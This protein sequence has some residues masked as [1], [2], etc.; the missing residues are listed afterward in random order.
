[1][2]RALRFLLFFSVMVGVLV[3][4]ILPALI[5][6]ML[7]QYVR[8]L[9][10]RADTLTVSV[11]TFDPALLS[12]RAGR[13]RVEGTNV[14]IGRATVGRLDITLGNVSFFDRSFGSVNGQ[15]DDVSVAA[16][17]VSAE[18]MLVNLVGPS[19]KTSATGQFD[20][21]QSEDMVKAAAKRAGFT[22]D[23]ATLVDGGLR[24]Q[25]GGIAVNA[26][27]SVEGG[28]L[29]LRPSVGSPMILLQPAPSDPWQLDEA[30]VSEGGIT[31]RGTFDA[32]RIASGITGQDK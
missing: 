5:S 32:A 2:L 3:F 30:Y 18:A 8:D 15:M 11:D 27:I 31:V 6:P 28:A 19:T 22:L 14:E 4:V 7:T 1:V 17:G 16:S 20:S 25:T 26:A 12:G 29:V 21:Q 9:G 23:K 10:V 13:L 24:L